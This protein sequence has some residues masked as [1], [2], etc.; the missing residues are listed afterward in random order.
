MLLKAFD[1]GWML[2]P[3]KRRHNALAA[4]APAAAG[5]HR[6]RPVGRKWPIQVFRELKRDVKAESAFGLIRIGKG[7]ECVQ[8]ALS[9]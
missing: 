1:N 9:H 6:F 8:S 7:P 2:F 3:W 5:Q 4:P